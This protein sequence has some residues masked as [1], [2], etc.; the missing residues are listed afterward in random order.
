ME[1]F[2]AIG[3]PVAVAIGHVALRAL[4]VNIGDAGTGIRAGNEPT[5]LLDG[6][7]HLA[8]QRPQLVRILQTAKK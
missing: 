6:A 8:A 2:Q 5:G 1:R 4:L 3:A 7:H